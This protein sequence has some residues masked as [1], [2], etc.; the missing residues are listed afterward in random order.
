MVMSGGALLI[1]T[2]PIADLAIVLVF[3]AFNYYRSRNTICGLEGARQEGNTLL[4]VYTLAHILL[5][6]ALKTDM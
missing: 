1:S 2:H 4:I 6:E 5:Q 3:T